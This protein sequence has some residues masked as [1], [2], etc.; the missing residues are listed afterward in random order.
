MI[1]RAQTHLRIFVIRFPILR[2][3][4][5]N[6]LNAIG[7]IVYFDADVSFTLQHAWLMAWANNCAAA[8][9]TNV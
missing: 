9:N 1:L 2:R 3:I 5:F 8:T 4:K 7:V 6:Q